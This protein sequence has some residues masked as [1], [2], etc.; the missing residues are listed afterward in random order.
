MKAALLNLWAWVVAHPA[1]TLGALYVALNALNASLPV[2]RRESSRLARVLDA[3]CIVTRRGSENATSWPVVGRSIARDLV[4]L[5]IAPPNPEHKKGAA[6]FSEA[7]LLHWVAGGAALALCVYA[8]TACLSGCS[9]TLPADLYRGVGIGVAVTAAGGREL[10]LLEAR[11]C[12]AKPSRFEAE[13]CLVPWRARWSSIGHAWQ[14]AASRAQALAHVVASV[15]AQLE[16]RWPAMDAGTGGAA[17]DAA[18]S[19]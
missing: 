7:L 18:V 11:E 8:L 9:P 19:E 15:D 1:E 16:R 17:G 5:S 10:A 6:G 4:T 12:L 2:E 14:G 3:L 13:A